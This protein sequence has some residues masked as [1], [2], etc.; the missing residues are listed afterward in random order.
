MQGQVQ[1][2]MRQPPLSLQPP[3]SYVSYET[4]PF[5]IWKLILHGPTVVKRREFKAVGSGNRAKNVADVHSCS[6]QARRA[7]VSGKAKPK[8]RAAKVRQLKREFDAAHQAGMADLRRG[9]YAALDK[10]IKKE[11]VL[12]KEQAELIADSRRAVKE[13][14]GPKRKSGKKR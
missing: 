12:I 2:T 5:A 13:R 11:R 1:Q 10:S 6:M 7:P 3:K 8:A 14:P 9:D 4:D